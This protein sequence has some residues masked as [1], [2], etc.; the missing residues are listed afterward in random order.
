MENVVGLVLGW[1]S[2][3]LALGLA[4]LGTWRARAL[5]IW[6]AAVLSAPTA[7][8]VSGAPAFPFLGVIPIGVLAIAAWTCRWSSPWPARLSVAAYGICLGALVYV[9]VAAG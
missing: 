4:V 5:P 7:F 6:I 2:L 3:S 9:V 1:P 8:Y